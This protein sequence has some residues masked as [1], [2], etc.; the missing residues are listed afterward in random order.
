MVGVIRTIDSARALGH[1]GVTELQ[2]VDS[3]HERKHQMAMHSDA[4]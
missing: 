1:G 4:F 2:V 3:M